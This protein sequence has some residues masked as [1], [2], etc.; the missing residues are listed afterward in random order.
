MVVYES[1]GFKI[2]GFVFGCEDI[3]YLEK[4]VYWGVEKEWLVFSDECYENVDE[5]KFMENFF[6]VV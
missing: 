2:Y 4:D 6:V 1:M 5:V 3:W